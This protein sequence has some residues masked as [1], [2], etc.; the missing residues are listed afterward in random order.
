MS[1]DCYGCSGGWPMAIEY[2]MDGTVV[3]PSFNQTHHDKNFTKGV[4][5]ETSYPYTAGQCNFSS[6]NTGS[7]VR[8]LTLIPRNNTQA[9]VDA[10]LRVGPW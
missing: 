5:T 1:P 2:I 7:L 10:V 6:S 8:N 4:D 3:D 9:L